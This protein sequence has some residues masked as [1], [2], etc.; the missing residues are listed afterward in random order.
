MEKI[1]C[2]LPGLYLPPPTQTEYPPNHKK[3]GESQLI[4]QWNL[5]GQGLKNS[6]AR[7]NLPLPVILAVFAVEAGGRA[8]DLNTGL[9]VIRCETRA[10]LTKVTRFP[11]GGAE[12][13]ARFGSGQNAEW[14]ALKAWMIMEPKRALDHTSLG[15]PQIMGFNCKI[16]GYQS[17]QEMLLDFQASVANQ[18]RGFEN[19]LQNYSKALIPALRKKDFHTFAKIYNGPGQPGLY[20]KNMAT[21]YQEA[22]RLGL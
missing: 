16:A 22:K 7:L 15:L 2:D 10:P 11:R 4:Q 3:A 21:F 17:P 18:L 12:F 13:R 1:L 8:Y 9:I 20:S 5:Y 6:A 14:Q 19:F